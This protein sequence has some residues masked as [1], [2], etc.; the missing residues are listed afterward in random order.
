MPEKDNNSNLFANRHIGP[1][2]EDIELMLT[3]LGYSSM[4]DFIE[5]VVP[6]DIR[7][8]SALR[9]D[10]DAGGSKSELEA[11]SAFKRTRVRKSGFPFL[12]RD[13]IL[14]L[15]CPTSDSTKHSGKPRLVHTIYT[16]SSRNLT[17]TFGSTPELPNNGY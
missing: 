1:R 3:T 12:Y 17:G 10:G 7:S 5:D 6:A 8:S 9:L 11:L 4:V 16:L 13:G 2:S 15:L 14:Q